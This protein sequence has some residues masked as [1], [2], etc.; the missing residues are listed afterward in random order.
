MLLRLN[1]NCVLVENFDNALKL[2]LAW[3]YILNAKLVYGKM[4][5][6]FFFSI[7]T[8]VNCG[9]TQDEKC[10]KDGTE[11]YFLFEKDQ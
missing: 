7:N 5:G 6:K 1:P 11:I 4:L 3:I 8:L 10:S 2:V 9:L